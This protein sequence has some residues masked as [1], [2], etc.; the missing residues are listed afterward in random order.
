MQFKLPDENLRANCAA[1]FERR[2]SEMAA[3]L[4]YRLV[5]TSGVKVERLRADSPNG[6]VGTALVEN[7]IEYVLAFRKPKHPR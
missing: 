3:A 5:A 1:D 2:A 4:N 6:L 7:P